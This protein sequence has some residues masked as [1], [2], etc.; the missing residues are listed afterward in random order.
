MA[1]VTQ[2]PVIELET[3]EEA[4]NTLKVSTRF[5]QLD[6]STKRKIP[7]VKIGRFVRYRRADLI[8]Y[9]NNNVIGGEA[10]Q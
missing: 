6:R 9:L 10:A 3:P 7:Y 4:A 8:Q 2:Q 1:D 5:L